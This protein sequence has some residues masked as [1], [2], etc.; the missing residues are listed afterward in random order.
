MWFKY[1]SII[2]NQG[3]I[4]LRRLSLYL[5]KGSLKLHLITGDDSD[6]YHTHPW[7]FTSFILFGGYKEYNLLTKEERYMYTYGGQIK[8]HHKK[9]LPF[10]ILANKDIGGIALGYK[11]RMFS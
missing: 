11:L 1:K 3:N 4:F 5:P 9:I 10:I 6:V 7:D 2:S 8:R